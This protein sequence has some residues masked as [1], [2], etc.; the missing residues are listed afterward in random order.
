MY[1]EIDDEDHAWAEWCKHTHL[2]SRNAIEIHREKHGHRILHI[3]IKS[4][5]DE[6][7]V[8][9]LY[10]DPK[11]TTTAELNF[12]VTFN[13]G[14]YRIGICSDG[15]QQCCVLVIPTTHGFYHIDCR[16]YPAMD[17]NNIALT[18]IGNITSLSELKLRTN[19]LKPFSDGP[20]T[21]CL[22][23]MPVLS[24]IAIPRLCKRYFAANISQLHLNINWKVL[25]NKMFEVHDYLPG[26]DKFQ[27]ELKVMIYEQIGAKERIQTEEKWRKLQVKKAYIKKLKREEQLRIQKMERAALRLIQKQEAER[28]MRKEFRDAEEKRKLKEAQKRKEDAEILRQLLS[29]AGRSRPTTPVTPNILSE[30]E[31]EDQKILM[32]D[33]KRK[34]E[35]MKKHERERKE[36][37]ALDYAATEIQK[38]LRGWNVRKQPTLLRIREWGQMTDSSIGSINT[39]RSL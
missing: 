6:D 28:I 12:L 17:L 15:R 1:G 27:K 34:K 16:T 20:D 30:Q 11:T 26:N 10:V 37:E 19:P 2:Y 32:Q 13:S 9:D 5:P 23:R 33:K 7:N 25:E 3:T 36:K 14:D 22:L 35:L 24:S 31:N 18:S 39:N 29:A 38:I 21:L 8:I 4:L